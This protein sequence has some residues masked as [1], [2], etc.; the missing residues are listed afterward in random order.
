[1]LHPVFSSSLHS[2]LE[3]APSPSLLASRRPFVNLLRPQPQP[4]PNRRMRRANTN[5]PAAPP[6]S[7]S[8]P[9]SADS[10]T[11]PSPPNERKGEGGG[12]LPLQQN[13]DEKEE[14]KGLTCFPIFS[15]KRNIVSTK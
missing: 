15:E 10:P 9:P 7:P 14:G 13:A 3:R 8:L 2:R 12:E 1:M 6:F 4:T 11:N 5:F